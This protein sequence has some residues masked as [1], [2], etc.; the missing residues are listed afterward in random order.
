MTVASVVWSILILVVACL[1]E[2]PGPPTSDLCRESAAVRALDGLTM[3]TL[4]SEGYGD[5]IRCL[6]CS[7]VRRSV[8]DSCQCWTS[9]H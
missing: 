9:V 4:A 3:W 8:L 6:L 7:I 5:P 2:L 1:F